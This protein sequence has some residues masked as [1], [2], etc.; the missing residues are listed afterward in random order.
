MAR[1][2]E[3]AT[4]GA[5]VHWLSTQEVIIF[6][7]AAT[8]STSCL[9][10]H[11]R[12][13]MHREHSCLL[14]LTDSGRASTPPNSSHNEVTKIDKIIAMSASARARRSLG[15]LFQVHG[16]TVQARSRRKK[17]LRSPLPTTQLGTCQNICTKGG[18]P[19]TQKTASL[20]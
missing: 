20:C 7:E 9:G 5:L 3:N 6:L 4:L 17:R 1:N 14:P 10:H 15:Q 12:W 19:G 18:R 2:R 13:L 16:P 11:G 8:R